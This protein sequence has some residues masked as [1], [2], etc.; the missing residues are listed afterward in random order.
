MTTPDNINRIA[1]M[2]GKIK[3]VVLAAG[4]SKRIQSNSSKIVHKILGK[5]IINFLLDSLVEA[6]FDEKNIIIVVGE[7]IKEIKNVVNRDVCYAIQKEQLGTAH[8]L[9][10]ARQYLKNFK[11]DTLVTVG[12]NPYLNSDEIKNLVNN[13]RENN[14]TCTFISAVFPDKPPKYGRVIRNE[15]DEVV[16]VVEEIE[17]SEQ[18]LKIREVNSSIYVFNNSKVFP[19][20]Y[21][22]DNKNEKGEYYLTD[23][24]KIL[25]KKKYR[26]NAVKADDRFISIGINDRWELQQAQRRINESRLK[27]L[28]LEQ[29]ITIL[30]P[31]TVTVEFDVSIDKDTVIYPFTYIEAGTRIGKNCTIG[32]FVHLKNVE[33]KNNEKISFEKRTNQSE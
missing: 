23:I 20:L 32:P 28:A 33:I 31:E 25:K 7:N 12:D 9:L 13:H 22:I 8:A 6:G 4:K 24:I 29:G 3:A 17:A 10:S 14:S 5:E 15:K 27:K 19:L 26:I 16:D 11:G 18:Q 2:K 30:Q 1:D 21:E